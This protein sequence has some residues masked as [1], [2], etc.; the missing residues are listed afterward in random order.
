MK[1]ILSLFVLLAI[2]FSACSTSNKA[3]KNSKEKSGED[4]ETDTNQPI[5]DLD[6]II[7]EEYM[8]EN[9]TEFDRSLYENRSSLSDQFA[10]IEQDMP[11]IFIKD[12]L[13]DDTYYDQ[14]AGYR[15]QL[16]TTRNVAE[17]DSLKMNFL[18]WSSENIDGYSPESYV[19]F[20]QPYYKVR[21][22]DFRDKQK[23][24]DFSR[25]IKNKF[26]EAWVVHDRIEPDSLPA[27]T[28]TI[29]IIR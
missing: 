21:V 18:I 1:K 28:T 22:G 19:L 10:T 23:A 8:L 24:N 4:Q 6:P 15:V 9:M 29:Q 17:A 7:M 2:I 27:D 13:R 11:E 20:Q 25:M 5:F 3:V 12:V 16:L 14:Y 26:P